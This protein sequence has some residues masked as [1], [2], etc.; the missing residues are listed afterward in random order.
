MKTKKIL[1]N[2]EVAFFCEQLAFLLPAG[3][4]PYE[5]IQLIYQ[6]TSSDQGKELL[7]TMVSSLQDG[8]SFSD[9]LQATQVFPAY[10]VDMISLGEESG[11]LDV[12]VQ[13]LADYYK[14]QCNISES[15][16][17]AVTYPMIM[18]VLMLMILVVLLTKILPIFN[19]VFQQLGSELSG[20]AGQLMRLGNTIRSLSGILLVVIALL[21]IALIFVFSSK[22]GKNW[23]HHV[24]QTN[25]V[26]KNLYLYIAYSRFAGALS[27]IT[28][29]GIDIFHGIDLAQKLVENELMNPKIDIC[30]K[31]LQNGNYLYE[32]MKKA[33]IFQSTQLRMLQIGH[34]SGNTEA[35][36]SN[37]SD[38]YEEKSLLRIQKSL[39]AIEP[40]LVILFSFIVG[41]ILI[42][43]IMPLIGIMSGL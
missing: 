29:A 42:S 5:A 6:D 23:I 1:S 32:A 27:L 18:V 11:N 19:Q 31:E 9:A 3:I 36:L 39:G 16:K 20:V 25:K 30:R 38:Y 40:T 26:T 13:K 12:I 8:S 15:I 14:Q 2:A 10:V 21:T 4:T 28:A 43:V 33:D 35:V 7:S 24:L 17:N 37:I 22:K 41:L 34:R